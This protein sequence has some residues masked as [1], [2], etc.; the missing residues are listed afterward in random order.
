MSAKPR[1]AII[2]GPTASGKSRL[3]IDAA[4]GLYG[5]GI[6]AEIISADSAQVYRYMNI[7]TD[8]LS[9]GDW[10]GVEHHMIDVVDPDQ[11]FSAA[12]FRDKAGEIIAR[13]EEEGKAQLVVGGTG[14]YV[15]ALLEGLFEGPGK[16][17]EIREQLRRLAGAEGPAHLHERLRKIDP[18]SA[19]RIHPNDTKRLIRALEVYELTGKTL[20]EHFREHDKKSPYNVLM[21]GLDLERKDLYKR[22][23]DRVDE[24]LQRGFLEEVKGLRQ[25]GYGPG[26]KSQQ[27]LGYRQLHLY[28]DGELGLDE[29]VSETKKKTRH[30]ARRQMIWLRKEKGIRWYHPEKDQEKIKDEV[31]KFFSSLEK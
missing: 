11:E 22:I 4:K 2:S 14:F 29:A 28:L 23:D 21:I 18:E 1:L 8:K 27:T 12:E 6:Q 13:L 20:S 9:E 15:R 19:N 26:L 5:L 3:A 10:Q 30:Y 16:D 7:G 24:M 25:R 31:L 17:E